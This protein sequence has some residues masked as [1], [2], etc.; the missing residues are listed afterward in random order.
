MKRTKILPTLLAL[1]VIVSLTSCAMF[2]KGT[3]HYSR[4]T[5]MGRELLD[6]KEARDNEVISEEE[7]NKLKKEIMEGGP[8]QIKIGDKD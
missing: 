4:T 7:Y 5:T 3:A 8:V 1:L 2:N 6:L